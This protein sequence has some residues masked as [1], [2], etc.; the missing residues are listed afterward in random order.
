MARD[1]YEAL[2]VPKAASEKEIRQAYRKL[3]RQ[4]HP[5]V[6]P[7][8]KSAETRFKEATTAFEVLS[9]KEKRE[10]YDK[11]FARFG[12]QWE[13]GAEIEEAQREAGARGFRY[14]TPGGGASYE[15]DVNDLFGEDEGGLFENLFRRSRR[16][17]R[18]K[19]ENV[20][21]PTTI[22]LEEAF[23]GAAR[24]LSIKMSETC[25]VCGG[26][27]RLTGGVCANCGGSGRELRPKRIEVK[28]P[29][30]V[31]TGSRVRIAGEGRPGTGGAPN[32]DLI[33]VVTVQPHDRFERKGADLYTDVSVPVVDAVL[34][35][36]VEVQT[37]K[38]RGMLRVPPL[39][40][41]G[42]VFRLGGQGMPRLNG[43]GRG[44]LYARVRVVLPE[45]LTNE[46]Q[47]LFEQLRAMRSTRK[48]AV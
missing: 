8:N 47:E 10:K 46:E 29:A 37:L 27:G 14:S 13:R 36:E 9:D 41:N 16:P 28:I 25:S 44:D 42:R 6:N 11:Y 18:Q 22:T 20:E 43:S 26:S 40:Q 1:Y 21:H 3:A 45:Q 2:G 5:D 23:T 19:G 35:S 4:Y 12:D 31:D 48:A 33:I 38:G 15:F 30:G 24:T 32:G 34:G 39:T 17:A 7:N